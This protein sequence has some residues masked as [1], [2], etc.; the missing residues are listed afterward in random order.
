MERRRRREKRRS[1]AWWD[2]ALCV[3][4]SPLF[5]FVSHWVKSGQWLTKALPATVVRG[6]ASHP[7]GFHGVLT[8][9]TQSLFIRDLKT[10]IY[11]C[12]FSFFVFLLPLFLF[13]FIFFV[14]YRLQ[15]IPALV[16]FSFIK[17]F[18]FK[19]SLSIWALSRL[20]T[21]LVYSKVADLQFYA[22][23][24]LMNGSFCLKH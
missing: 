18:F 5:V 8:R 1:H 14:I 16:C 22:E 11:H 23:S 12:M 21:V 17:F 10:V 4:K 9:I 15:I 20:L 13:C 3:I 6:V 19:T 24:S 2:F 7:P